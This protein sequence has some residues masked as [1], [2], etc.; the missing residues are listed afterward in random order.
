MRKAKAVRARRFWLSG[1]MLVALRCPLFC[2]VRDTVRDTSE[3]LAGSALVLPDRLDDFRTEDLAVL[4]WDLVEPRHP[5]HK[6]PHRQ[7]PYRREL[8]VSRAVVEL[9]TVS[10]IL[11]GRLPSTR[12]PS[13]PSC[14]SSSSSRAPQRLSRGCAE[15]PRRGTAVAADRPFV[16][17]APRRGACAGHCGLVAAS[18]RR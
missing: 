13:T 2:A 11:N 3:T 6:S 5:M 1:A 18:L 7:W 10:S 12:M 9:P 15:M 4:V 8:D 16:V 14:T 17:S